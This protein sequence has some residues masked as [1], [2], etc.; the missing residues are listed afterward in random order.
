MRT[1]SPRRPRTATARASPWRN[2]LRDAAINP[3]EVQYLNAHAT[4]TPLGDSAE[5]I[6][7]KRA[8]G[9]H[10]KKLAVSSTK[11]MTGHLLGAAGVVE[12]IFSRARDP[13]PGRAADD[14]S[15]RIPIRTAISITCPTRRAR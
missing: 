7:I 13:R 2:A 15:T 6:A 14:Q 3:S 5:T 10:A 1:T 8:F 11:S 4:S 12:A 9:D